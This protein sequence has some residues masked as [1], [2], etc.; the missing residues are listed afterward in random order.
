MLIILS[1]LILK[2]YRFI[3][4]N[5]SDPTR[6]SHI[7]ALFIFSIGLS[8]LGF[9]VLITGTHERYMYHGYPFLM[10]AL[11]YFWLSEDKLKLRWVV[12]LAVSALAYGV[13]VLSIISIKL[14]LFFPF[15][16]LYFQA[17][18]HLFL[19]V[20]FLAFWLDLTLR[21]LDSKINLSKHY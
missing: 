18:M 21:P 14:S 20:F 1:T 9:N 5:N 3:M 16:N 6:F 2:V 10:I 12:L 7:A 8:H 15:Q 13:Y 17:A 4:K 11:F 19:L